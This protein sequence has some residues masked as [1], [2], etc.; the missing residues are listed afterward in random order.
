MGTLGELTAHL[1][2]N[3]I[4]VQPFVGE[5]RD[6]DVNLNA[7]DQ[8][9]HGGGDIRLMGAFLAALEGA[10]VDMGTLSTLEV[11]VEGHRIA[12]AAEES[13]RKGGQVVAL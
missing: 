8:F 11:S 1:K 6:I 4:H 5:G 3:H 9:G 12:L 2:R 10:E 7:D 13:R